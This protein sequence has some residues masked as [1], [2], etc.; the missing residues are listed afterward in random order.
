M[1]SHLMSAKD[2]FYAGVIAGVLVE[3]IVLLMA[4]ACFFLIVLALAAS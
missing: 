1:S 4:A 3:I 2:T